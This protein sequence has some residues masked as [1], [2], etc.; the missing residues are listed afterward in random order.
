VG[1]VI[2][3]AMRKFCGSLAFIA[4]AT[5]A[6]A[7]GNFELIALEGASAGSG[8]GTYRS[9]DSYRITDAGRIVFNGATNNLD[10]FVAVARPEAAHLVARA[11]LQAPDLPV[12]V[13]YDLPWDPKI[14]SDG[15]I[16]FASDLSGP[17]WNSGGTDSIWSGDPSSLHPVVR[18]G[19]I[20]P[21]TGG[22]KFDVF[23]IDVGLG[24]GGNVLFLGELEDGTTG[25]WAGTQNA[26]KLVALEGGVTPGLPGSAFDWFNGFSQTADIN[27]HGK[28]AFGNLVSSEFESDFGVWEWNSGN[29]QLVAHEGTPVPDFGPGTEILTLIH[30]PKINDDGYVAFTASAGVDDP[31]DSH[32]ALFLKTPAGIEAIYGRGETPPGFPAGSI[33]D[34]QWGF[35]QGVGR[36]L[37]YASSVIL[38]N[39][40]FEEGLFAYEDGVN[41]LVAKEGEAIPGSVGDRHFSTF[42][43]YYIGDDGKVAFMGDFAGDATGRGIW[44]ENANG[45][46][47]EVVRTGMQIEVSPGDLRTVTDIEWH[48]PAVTTYLPSNELGQILFE[49]EFGSISALFLYTPAGVPGDYNGDSLVDAADYTGWRDQL[50]TNANLPNDETP[51]TVDPSDFGV[52]KSHFGQSVGSGS[53]SRLDRSELAPEPTSVGLALLSLLGVVS[54]SRCH[55]HR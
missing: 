26:L 15:K 53:I 19:D 45:D 3:R 9:F 2:Q 24:D 47:I 29:L 22:R 44:V 23:D 7:A 18:R 36:R 1:G 13:V 5:T 48:E 43:R 12:G 31:F 54:L 40:D 42:R 20:A 50:G 11:G 4:L 52:W 49:A 17:G 21:G 46:L 35:E 27:R 30:A 14:S 38:P 32:E 41:R 16:A 37:V 55:G 6:F 25:L 33:F 34:L 8:N 39:S 10:H 51:G 28:I